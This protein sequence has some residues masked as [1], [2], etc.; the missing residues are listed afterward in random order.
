MESLGQLLDHLKNP[1]IRRRTESITEELLQNPLIRALRS[2]YPE[3]DDRVIRLNLSKLYQYAGD[4]KHCE[5]CPGLEHC[6]N[7]F[8]G[9]FSKLDIERVNGTV[10][11]Y[12]RKAPCHLQVAKTNAE[13][14]RKRIRSFYVDDHALNEGYNNMEI[15]AKD[16]L[17]APAVH[18]IFRYIQDVKENGLSPRGLY[19]TGAFGTGKTYLMCYL[20]HELAMVGYTGVIVY[21]PDFVEDLKSMMQEGQK[22]KEMTET[23]KEC[24]LLIF[25]DIGAENLNPWVRD[26]VLG[27]ILNYRMNRK[28]TFYTSNY[29]LDGLERHLSFTSKDGEELH[30]GQRLMNR[31]APFV[32]VVQLFGENQRG[33]F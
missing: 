4:H 3:I 30:K 9:H 25:D 16:R 32:D 14:I 5:Q 29:P 20:L 22:L 18:Q 7:D 13:M 10:E 28:P 17:R 31:I 11:I 6:P 24:D 2:E 12:E 8:Q 33:K 21:M 26:H 1:D 19:L 27:S 15:M 23:M